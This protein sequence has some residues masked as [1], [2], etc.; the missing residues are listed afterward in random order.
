MTVKCLFRRSDGMFVGG[1]RYDG[2]PHDPASHVQ[3]DLSDYPDR[4]T[5]RW[6]GAIGVRVATA[7]E[8][9]DFDDVE[10]DTKAASD[11]D[12][13]KALKALVIWLA[14][15]LG[16]TPAQARTEIVAIYKSLPR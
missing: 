1:N 16:V 13:T 2:I 6:D 3:L 9:S 10:A 11:F 14:G 15:K 5:E 8:I 7:Q 12:E 4:R